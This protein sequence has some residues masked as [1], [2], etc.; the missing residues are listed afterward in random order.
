MASTP[1]RNSCPPAVSY[2]ARYS[3]RPNTSTATISEPMMSVS[4]V[5]SLDGCSLGLDQSSSIGLTARLLG[6]RTEHR[7][8]ARPALHGDQQSGG[9][10]IPQRVVEVVGESAEDDVGIL[11]TQAGGESADLRLDRRRT[12]RHRGVDR[13]DRLIARHQHV[14]Q[15]LDPRRQGI[16]ALH[17]ADRSTVTTLPSADGEPTPDGHDQRR[18]QPSRER[19]HQCADAHR[20]KESGNEVGVER[21]SGTRW[22]LGPEQH[23]HRGDSRNRRDQEDDRLEA[24]RGPPVAHRS[25]R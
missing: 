25:D 8:G 20:R 5:T 3:A 12:R 2:G 10:E 24:H 11:A 16:G 9:D 18:D 4:R 21:P 6:E 13:P 7:G 23:H 19:Q 15:V 14:T 17:V 22:S 1:P